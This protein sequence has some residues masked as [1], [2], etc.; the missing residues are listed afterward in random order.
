[1]YTSDNCFNIDVFNSC[2]WLTLVSKSY[3]SPTRPYTPL[4]YHTPTCFVVLRGGV[5]LH[6]L[7]KINMTSARQRQLAFENTLDGYCDSV[8]SAI[9]DSEYVI[10]TWACHTGS[11][12]NQLRRDS[13]CIRIFRNNM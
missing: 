1:M 3:S 6:C 8:Y 10:P 9:S 2:W 5:H 12:V 11:M 4:L 13:D 7:L